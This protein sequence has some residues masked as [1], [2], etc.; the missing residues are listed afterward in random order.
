MRS[1]AF[2]PSA[3]Y[4]AYDQ[5]LYSAL[6][7]AAFFDKETFGADKLLTGMNA[8]PWPEFLAQAPLSDLAVRRDIAR[9]YTEKVG[10]SSRAFRGGKARQA[11]EDQLC[12]LFAEIL[13]TDTGGAAILSNL[14]ARSVL[15]GHRSGFGAGLLRSRR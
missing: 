5:K 2:R 1:S 9:V 7:T 15:R 3:F 11:G 4:R 6:G 12:R 14:Y 8:T 10:L 13:Q